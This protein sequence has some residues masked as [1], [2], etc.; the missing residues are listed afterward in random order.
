VE[1]KAVYILIKGQQL[2]RFI[3]PPKY[4]DKINFDGEYLPFYGYTIISMVNGHYGYSQI[5]QFPKKTKTLSKYLAPLPASSYHVTIFDIFCERNVPEK[6][7]P[8]SGKV[9]SEHW[10]RAMRYLQED[11]T[12]AKKICASVTKELSFKKTKLHL[13]KHSGGVFII[14]GHLTNEDL[15][16]DVRQ[17]LLSIFPHTASP[18]LKYHLTLG[19]LFKEI[20][21]G[22]MENINKELDELWKL[23]NDEYPLQVPR[24]QFFETMTAFIPL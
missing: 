13:E 17:Q 4:P 16:S 15:L 19:Y 20:V 7:T 24:V 10:T 3:H 11:L 21:E 14:L 22:D 9:P 8:A 18:N 2:T 23:I 12:A 1:S 5:E 6:Y